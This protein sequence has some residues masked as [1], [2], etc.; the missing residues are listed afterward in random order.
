LDLGFTP[1]ADDADALVKHVAEL[2]KK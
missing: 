1:K 2:W